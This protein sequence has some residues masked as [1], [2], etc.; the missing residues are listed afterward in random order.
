M[1]EKEKREYNKSTDNELELQPARKEYKKLKTK[2]PSLN[3]WGG[4]KK[5]KNSNSDF[6]WAL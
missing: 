1:R 2:N 4:K 5:K 6:V 3:F